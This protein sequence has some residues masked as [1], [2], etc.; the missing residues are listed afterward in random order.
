MRMK[1]EARRLRAS[2][3][4][5]SSLDAA[6]Q[7]RLLADELGQEA[8]RWLKRI[9]SKTGAPFRYLLVAEE[10]KTGDPHLHVLLH[11]FGEPITKRVL[12]GSW[13]TGFTHW[14]LVGDD[15]RAAYYVCKYLSKDLR[16]RVRASLGYGQADAIRLITERIEKMS[17]TLSR[18]SKSGVSDDDDDDAATM[19]S[20]R[21]RDDDDD[22]GV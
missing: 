19:A 5:I 22:K 10:H 12:E 20:Q 6:E 8:T 11:E 2:R 14:R 18:V 15:R 13:V 7:F 4:T 16:T 9:R 17:D 3:E 1:V 21:R